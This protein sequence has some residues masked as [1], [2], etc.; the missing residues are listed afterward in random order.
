VSRA[1]RDKWDERYRTGAY[2]D[3]AHPTALLADWL[4]R[5]PRGRALDVACGAGRNA[6]FLA[7]HDYRVDA[8]DISAVGLARAHDDAA[9]RGLD[10]NWLCAD[11]EDPADAVLPTGPYDLIVWV[12]YVHHALLPHLA[13]RL[14]RGGHLL[15]EQHL[16]TSAEVVGPKNPAF[17]YEPQQ[18]ER[19]ASGLRV[20][21]Y[22]EG[23]IVDPD[24][25]TAALAQLIAAAAD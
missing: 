22:R 15:C 1:E 12:R 17:R 21:H 6:L 11:L 19:A 14:A 3:R 8:L 20:V 18:L 23:L 16:R 4:A 13:A 2:E 7:A 24:G 10:V 5:L 9:R 25:R